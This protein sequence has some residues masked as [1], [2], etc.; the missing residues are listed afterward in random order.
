MTILC[1]F[2]LKIQFLLEQ[3]SISLQRL[4]HFFLPQHCG[5]TYIFYVIAEVFF[6]SFFHKN[7]LFQLCP[8]GRKTT[9]RQEHSFPTGKS[10]HFRRAILNSSVSVLFSSLFAD[11]KKKITH[12]RLE[13]YVLCSLERRLHKSTKQSFLFICLLLTGK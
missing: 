3:G 1:H 4:F 2:I 11:T 7:D 9:N 12:G 13:I 5:I 8:L 10:L 6:K